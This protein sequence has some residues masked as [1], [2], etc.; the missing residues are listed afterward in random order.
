VLFKYLSLLFGVFNMIASIG[1]LALAMMADASTAAPRADAP[2]DPMEKVVCRRYV[3]T[4]S[5]VRSKRVCRTKR[6]WVNVDQQGRKL[7]EDIYDK[8]INRP[9]RDPQ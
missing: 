6:D 9:T 1:L 3:E 5:L 7:A 2:V 8:G 4:G